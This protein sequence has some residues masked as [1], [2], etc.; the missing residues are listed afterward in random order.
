MRLGDYPGKPN[1]I[2]RVLVGS[3]RRWKGESQR[4]GRRKRL[5]PMLL[6][7]KAKNAGGVQKLKKARK[8]I[9]CQILK[10]N[11]LPVMS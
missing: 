9:I 4:D 1:I 7:L 2:T 5:I 8:W 10:A 6:A 11:V 3:R